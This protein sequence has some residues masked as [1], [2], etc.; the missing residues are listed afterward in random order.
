LE[1]APDLEE[2]SPQHGAGQVLSLKDVLALRDDES[3]IARFGG[4]PIMRTKRVGL[5]RNSAIVAANTKSV[6]LLGDLEDVAL[7]DPSP[8]VRQHAVWAYCILAKMAGLGRK[9]MDGVLNRTGSDSAS[10]VRAETK[11]CIERLL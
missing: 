8:L 3:F 1:R 6:S 10:E 4:T 7:L 5:L 11:E 9:E 2:F